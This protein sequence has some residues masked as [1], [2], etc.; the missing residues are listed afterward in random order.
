MT[1]I[2]VALAS[3]LGLF[4]LTIV[5]LAVAQE[6]SKDFFSDNFARDVV[7]GEP[8]KVAPDEKLKSGETSPERESA[9]PE[10]QNF[11]TGPDESLSPESERLH[12]EPE[13]RNVM[14]SSEGIPIQSLNA[15][16]NV[17]ERKHFLEHL[18]ELKDTI[19]AHNI[20]PGTIYMIGYPEFDEPPDDFF[21]I[22]IRGGRATGDYRI[23][24]QYRTNL[25]PTWIIR[26]NEG[27]VVLEGAPSLQKFI[28]SK[29]Q[30]IKAHL[31]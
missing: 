13:Q 6:R 16:F 31:E 20:Q 25:S 11:F 26:T 4:F 28:N 23:I 17:Q 7:S 27:D 1:S 2:K 12:T 15:V 3:T 18:R 14:D 8:K 9:I 24:E 29:G 19:V 5:S 30:L 21:P 10:R 22:I